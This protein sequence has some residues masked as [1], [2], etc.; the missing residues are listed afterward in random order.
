MDYISISTMYE[1]KILQNESIVY[2][3]AN[4]KYTVK[5]YLENGFLKNI[6]SSKNIGLFQEHL[7]SQF[8][9][10]HTTYIINLKYISRMEKRHCNYEIFLLGTPRTIPLSK[11]RKKYVMDIIQSFS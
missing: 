7:P 5:H 6:C 10:V 11:R 4:G 9:R 8:L 2:F 3:E 1:V